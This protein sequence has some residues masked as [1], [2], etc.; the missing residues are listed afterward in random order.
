MASRASRPDDDTARHSRTLEAE[1]AWPRP[2]RRALDGVGS[3][4]ESARWAAR[5]CCGGLPRGRRGRL[6]GPPHGHGA[7]RAPRCRPRRARCH[8]E[9]P[10]RRGRVGA[11]GCWGRRLRPA[12]R[13]RMPP[14]CSPGE[15]SRPSAPPPARARVPV[16]CDPDALLSLFTVVSGGS[17]TFLPRASDPRPVSREPTQGPPPPPPCCPVLSPCPHPDLRGKQASSN[18]IFVV[19]APLCFGILIF[20]SY[21]LVPSSTCKC[22]QLSPVLKIL[23]CFTIS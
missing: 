16:P 20:Y 15:D 10:G 21:F 17:L 19:L 1:S 14:S 9:G 12:E 8:G 2:A 4:V 3:Q 23:P 6:R 11:A 5:A 13:P 18:T 7:L 22:A